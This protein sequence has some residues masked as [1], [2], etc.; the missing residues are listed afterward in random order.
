[1]SSRSLE[2]SAQSGK[3]FRFWSLPFLPQLL[4]PQFLH[5]PMSPK[6][7]RCGLRL[8]AREPNWEGLGV[9][10]P[11]MLPRGRASW[12]E[13]KFRP[14]KIVDQKAFPIFLSPC[15]FPLMAV[16]EMGKGRDSW[17]SLLLLLLLFYLP[18]F[19]PACHMEPI[20]DMIFFCP[21]A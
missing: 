20:P 4:A 21:L 15:F 2:L 5:L 18:S 14:W 6:E 9:F 17:S 12:R 3:S 16:R 8:S 19:L 1:M 11:W 13:A 7:R 10:W